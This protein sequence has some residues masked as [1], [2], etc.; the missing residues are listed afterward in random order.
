MV[1]RTIDSDRINA[2]FYRDRLLLAGAAG[3]EPDHG[4]SL[5]VTPPNDPSSKDQIGQMWLKVAFAGALRCPG[6]EQRRSSLRA[7][8]RSYFQILDSFFGSMLQRMQELKLNPAEFS[9]SL[10]ENRPLLRR[11]SESL[12]DLRDAIQAF[13][14]NN[15]P[16]VRAHVIA[17]EGTSA[18]FSGDASPSVEGRLPFITGSYIDTLVLPDPVQRILV[19][20]Q[21][22][23]PERQVQLLVKHGL[24]TLRYR[25]LALAD[26][27]DPILVVGPDFFLLDDKAVTEVSKGAL[28]DVD[29]H[30]GRILGCAPEDS[31]ETLPTGSGSIEPAGMTAVSVPLAYS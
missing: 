17:L 21:S 6:H 14:W 7:I 10:I 30:L 19:L 20:G 18:I 8:Q 4:V 15:G 3:M 25:G 1:Q 5:G 16:I 26:V 24:N 9:F 22:F 31:V 23:R 2:S 28:A 29:I 13:W 27:P 11:V 12:G